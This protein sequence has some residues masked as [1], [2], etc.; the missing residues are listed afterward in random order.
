MEFLQPEKSVG[1]QEG[2]YFG[3]TEVE[4]QRAPIE[5]FSLSGIGVFVKPCSVK[6]GQSKRVFGEMARNPVQNDSNAL[7]VAAIDKMTKLVRISKTAGRR[8]VAGDLVTP[9]TIERVL[10]NG[11]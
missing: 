3:P 9:G 5:V 4:A 1:D 8:V 6:L 10:G 2:T 7:F 11:Q